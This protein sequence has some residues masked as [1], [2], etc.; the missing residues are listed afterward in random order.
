MPLEIRNGSDLQRSLFLLVH[1]KCHVQPPLEFS[2]DFNVLLFHRDTLVQS[3]TTVVLLVPN[4][5]AT[6][7]PCTVL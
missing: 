1:S 4:V 2:G 3:P 7:Y 5:T 6:L